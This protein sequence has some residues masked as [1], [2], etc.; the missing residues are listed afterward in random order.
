[1]FPSA[2]C[3]S[4]PA[5]PRPPIEQIPGVLSADLR[6]ARDEAVEIIT[7]PMLLQSYGLALDQPD[8]RPSA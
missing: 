6:G 7:E 4:S 5:R 2:P 3:C 1:M 8:L